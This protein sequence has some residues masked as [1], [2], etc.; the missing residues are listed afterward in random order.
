M[1]LRSHYILIDATVFPQAE[2]K[3]NDQTANLVK[4]CDLIKEP[5]KYS[6]K[7]VNLRAI[8]VAIIEPTADGYTVLY[9]PECDGKGNRVLIADNFTLRIPEKENNKLLPIFDEMKGGM[10]ARAEI[11]VSGMFRLAK[12]STV[13]DHTLILEVLTI[14]NVKKVAED[15]PWPR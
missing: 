7:M 3:D 12:H 14:E 5:E 9:L 1:V 13:K 6:G 8:I 2:A 11:S 4:Y 10:L 15:V